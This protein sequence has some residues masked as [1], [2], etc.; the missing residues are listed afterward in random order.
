MNHG[1]IRH[2]RGWPAFVLGVALCAPVILPLALMG[3]RQAGRFLVQDLAGD[4]AGGPVG[5][6]L[7]L[8]WVLAL[9]AAG[10]LLLA[11]GFRPRQ[12]SRRT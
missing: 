1:S 3:P 10:I 11:H 12:P 6:A 2:R 5:L 7:L 4:F 9:P 8:V